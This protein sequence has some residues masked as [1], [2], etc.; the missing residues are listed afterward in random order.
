MGQLHILNAEV[1][2]EH[3]SLQKQIPYPNPGDL[4]L[5]NSTQYI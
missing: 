1:N 5:A 2:H 3:S 4:Y